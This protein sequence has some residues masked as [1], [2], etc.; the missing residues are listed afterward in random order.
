MTLFRYR[1]SATIFRELYSFY[2]LVILGRVAGTDQFTLAYRSLLEATLQ[3]GQTLITPVRRSTGIRFFP[4]ITWLA[5]FLGGGSFMLCGG[6]FRWLMILH[7]IIKCYNYLSLLVVRLDGRTA[8]YSYFFRKIVLG[9]HF[10]WFIKNF[11]DNL[12]FIA[13]YFI[14]RTFSMLRV[15]LT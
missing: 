6:G 5:P 9:R 12:K 14:F 7:K 1:L 11:I 13:C 15:W 2:P 10:W 8:S 4:K 3:I